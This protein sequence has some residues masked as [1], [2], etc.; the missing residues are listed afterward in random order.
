MKE[1]KRTDPFLNLLFPDPGGVLALCFDCTDRST[2][3]GK[4]S[5]SILL[6]GSLQLICYLYKCRAIII[7]STDVNV[8]KQCFLD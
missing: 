8:T 4:N 1:M 3:I 7:I 6:F 5:T 2:F